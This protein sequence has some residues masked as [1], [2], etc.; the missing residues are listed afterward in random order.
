M[1][2]IED[3]KTLQRMGNQAFAQQ[4]WQNAAHFYLHSILMLRHHL[5]ALLQPPAQGATLGVICLSIAVQ[6]LADCYH[7][8][9]RTKRSTLVLNRALRDFQMLQS[10]L[11][12]SHPA[13]VALLRESCRLRQLL[14]AHQ[15]AGTKLNNP[16]IPEIWGNTTSARLH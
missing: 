5:P 3:W 15:A 4:H 7:R 16:L 1:E 11:C 12:A 2:L 13:T 10:L 9:G 6:N 14:Y 8:Q